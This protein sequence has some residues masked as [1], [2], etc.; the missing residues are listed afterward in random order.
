MRWRM[1]LCLAGAAI[2]LAQDSSVVSLSNGVQVRIAASGA[3]SALKTELAPATGN[4]FYRIFRDENGLAVYAYELMVDRTPDGTQFRL[5]EKPAG[6]E[7]A[8]RF[9]NVDGGKPTP[10][11]LEPRQSPLL[12][13]GGSF[14]IDV[15]T[16]PGIGGHLTDTVQVQT[17]QRG[18]PA[19]DREAQASAQFRFAS[20]RVS[21]NGV[22]A[23]PE[24]AGALVSGRY[25]MFYLPGRGGFFFS[26]EPVNGT[27][28]AQ[29]GRVD[30]REL[31]FTVDNESYDCVS[32]S[33]I[34]VN[35]ERGQVWVFHDA[36]YRPTG[37]W[38]KS[39][40]NRSRDEFFTAASDSLGWWL[41]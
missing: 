15:P 20:L 29:I 32:E 2:C 39:E 26:A 31:R 34:L 18:V 13:S 30:Q 14:E 6:T 38:T 37:N 33:P 35:S 12:D 16:D 11:V 41:R 28:F 9:P 40:P 3:P 22:A 5:T 27:A 10:T 24:G 23:S 7:F 8:E 25:A 4:S 1:G 21:I 19:L 36:G 17:S